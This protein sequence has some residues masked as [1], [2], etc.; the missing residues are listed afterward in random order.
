[1]K[2]LIL[3]GPNLNLLGKREEAFYG[4]E[5]F[6]KI[7]ES[8]KNHFENMDLDY[9][10]SNSEG[11]IV[12]KIQQSQDEGFYGIVLNAAAYSH[13]S[14]AIRD[15]IS[16]V[17][18]PVVEVHLSN[19]YAREPFRHVSVISAVCAGTI[20]GFGKDSYKLA[21]EWF[22]YHERTPIGFKK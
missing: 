18:I 13:Y 8:L 14:I 4:R 21:I 12:D 1:M 20:T 16:L 22:Q 9:F 11:S 2:I 7:Y 19:I 5:D 3:N 10:Q 15:A 17:Q 6:E